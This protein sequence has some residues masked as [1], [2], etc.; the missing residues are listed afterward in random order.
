MHFHID[1]Q[2]FKEGST[3][4]CYHGYCAYVPWTSRRPEKIKISQG[5]YL[6]VQRYFGAVYDYAR[7]A[8][9]E[10]KIGVALNFTEIIELKFGIK[11]SYIALYLKACLN[12]GC[13]NI[14]NKIRLHAQFFF[15]FQQH[16]LR[17]AFHA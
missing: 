4:F 5:Q 3:S 9:S 6:P 16:L 7:K 12:C 15:G 17:S 2:G 1:N 10:K 11:L 13:L 14:C 8:E